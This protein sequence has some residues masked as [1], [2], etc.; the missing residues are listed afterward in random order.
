MGKLSSL[1]KFIIRFNPRAWRKTQAVEKI[2]LPK[3][4]SLKTVKTQK[5]LKTK[6]LKSKEVPKVKTVK[7]DKSF[8]D[9]HIE[10]ASKVDVL[11][12]QMESDGKFDNISTTPDRKIGLTHD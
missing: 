4:K 8:V 12:A 6:K 9:L 10:V 5:T 1:R 7:Q 3:T 11:I 2:N